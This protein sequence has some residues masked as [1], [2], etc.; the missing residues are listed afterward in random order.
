M[1]PSGAGITPGASTLPSTVAAPA[2]LSPMVTKAPTVAVALTAM[3]GVVWPTVITGG[4][5]HTICAVIA[6]LGNPGRVHMYCNVAP[7]ATAVGAAP[8][9]PA[10]ANST[11]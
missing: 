4:A 9:N 8:H 10:A 3:A 11:T 1:V 7:D 2:R 6:W 5:C